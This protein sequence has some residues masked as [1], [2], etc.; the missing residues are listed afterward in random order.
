MRNLFTRTFLLVEKSIKRA[1]ITFGSLHVEERKTF[2]T[3]NTLFAIKER[4]GDRTVCNIMVLSATLIILFDDVVDGLPPK[5]PIGGVKIR[6]E[7]GRT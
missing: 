5:Y 6:L 2:V 4:T 1:S 7:Y 3:L